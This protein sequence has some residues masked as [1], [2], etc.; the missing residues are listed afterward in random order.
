[1]GAPPQRGAQIW[2]YGALGPAL[3]AADLL[4]VSRCPV[5]PLSRNLVLDEI[6]AAGIALHPVLS[7]GLWEVYAIR[8]APG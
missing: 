5:S 7:V 6:T 2:H 4:A 1:V 3:G 8:G